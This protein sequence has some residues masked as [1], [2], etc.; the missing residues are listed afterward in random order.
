MPNTSPTGWIEQ[1][2]T[3]PRIRTRFHHSQDC[4]RIRRTETLRKVERPMGSP[5]CPGCEPARTAS[6]PGLR[7]TDEG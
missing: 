6:R 5:W 4:A 1:L 2:E 7:A 3:S